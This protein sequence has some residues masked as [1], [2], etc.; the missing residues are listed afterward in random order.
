MRVTVEFIDRVCLTYVHNASFSAVAEI[1]GA[2]RLVES[3][4]VPL[5]DGL[6]VSHWSEDPRLATINTWG[7]GVL[8]AESNGGSAGAQPY[9][10]HQ[11]AKSGYSSLTVCWHGRG[12]HYNWGDRRNLIAY[13]HRGR[14]AVAFDP[15][16]DQEERLG[17]ATGSL[18]LY[19]AEHP[20]EGDWRDSGVALLEQLAHAELSH[21]IVW[22]VGNDPAQFHLI[23][24]PSVVLPERDWLQFLGPRF[25]TL[26]EWDACAG[27]SMRTRR[28]LAFSPMPESSP[29]TARPG[30]PPGTAAPDSPPPPWPAT[31]RATGR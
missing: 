19:L 7:E 29:A 8:V 12:I 5:S 13:V 26:N 14:L 2:Q 22:G 25:L 10:L 1:F 18:D 4:Y 30:T 20:L 28:W 6:T 3:V 23:T 15:V 27:S 21:E 9:F 24:Q 11:I 31:G 16:L 17:W